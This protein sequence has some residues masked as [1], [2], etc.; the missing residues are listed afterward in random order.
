MISETLTALDPH[1]AIEQAKQFFTE[2][3]S[4]LPATVVEEGEASLTVETFRSRVAVSAFEDPDGRGTRVRVST[5]R[6]NDALGKLLTLLA[7]GESAAP[8]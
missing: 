5:L 6:R 2:A 3:N 1:A 8:R 7:T 4:P